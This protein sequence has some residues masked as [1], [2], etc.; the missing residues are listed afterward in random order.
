[1]ANP[2]SKPNEIYLERIYNAPVK[3][4]W[5]AM[6]DP[7]QAKHWWG[8]R[9]FT[10]TTISKD[11]RTGGTW[12]YIMHGPEGENSKDWP[13]TTQYLE[14]TPYKRMVYDHGGNKD[15][16]P[17]FRVTMNFTELT[18][19]KT[20]M[21]MWMALPSEEAAKA[22]KGYIKQAS[23]DSCW[24]RFGEFLEEKQTKKD[25]FIINR[26]FKADINTMYDVW[27]NPEHLT[28]WLSPT[29]TNMK[30]ISADIKPGGSAFYQMGNEQMTMYGKCHYKEMIKPTRLVY[31]QNFSDKDGNLGKHPMAPTWPTYM[32]T[33]IDFT[34]ESENETRV[35]ITWEIYGEATAEEKAM[36]HNAKAGMT[37]GWTGSF[38]KL[39]NYLEKL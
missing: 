35:T 4:V 17:M 38:D 19:N 9:G 36:F 29:G 10:L 13:N 34:A 21:E 32:L 24:D 31:T 39:E 3:M 27:T 12:E 20:K 8:P 30:Y 1:M 11:M 5:D 2:K 26:T 16:K 18:P 28:K 22:T 33:T 6:A 7:E 23:G 37:G 25:V 15:Q 14:V